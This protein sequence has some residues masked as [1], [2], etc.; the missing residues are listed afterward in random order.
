MFARDCH[1]KDSHLVISY[2]SQNDAVVLYYRGSFACDEFEYSQNSE[3]PF[4]QGRTWLRQA[5]GNTHH[6]YSHHGAQ[7][8]R[9]SLLKGLAYLVSYW[10]RSAWK[11]HWSRKGQKCKRRCSML[12]NLHVAL[13]GVLF[14]HPTQ[15]VCIQPLANDI[16]WKAFLKTSRNQLYSAGLTEIE[17]AITTRWDLTRKKF[18]SPWY[19]LHARKT[20]SS[21][22]ASGTKY[23]WAPRWAPLHNMPWWQQSGNNRDECTFDYNGFWNI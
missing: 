7:Q 20:N 14:I 17:Y 6:T 23:E 13:Q 8:L 5:L 4:S 10:C 19:R 21:V 16:C 18:S 12:C 2:T 15:M 3:W 9:V 22:G 1:S 11:C